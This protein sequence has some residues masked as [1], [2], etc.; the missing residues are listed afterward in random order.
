MPT[1]KNNTGDPRTLVGEGVKVSIP[2]HS[3]EPVSAKVFGVLK[4]NKGI[5]KLF[6]LGILEDIADA[7]PKGPSK[8]KPKDVG[9]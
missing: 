2:A 3:A 7:K 9:I 4:Q 5:R 6:D 8:S 1:I